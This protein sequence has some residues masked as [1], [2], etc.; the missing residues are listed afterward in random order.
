VRSV[1]P[2]RQ[3]ELNI[4][5]HADIINALGFATIQ[6]SSETIFNINVS[7]A[8][9]PTDVIASNIQISSNLLVGIVHP[10]VD[11]QFD[12]LAGIG[13]VTRFDSKGA[14]DTVAGPVHET[15]IHLKDS[16]MIFQIG[17]NPGQD[18]G[19]AIGRMDARAL[20]IKGISVTDRLKANEA[21]DA[22][23]RAM[24]MVSSARSKLGAIQNRLEHAVTSLGVAI[25]NLSSSES[26]IRDLDMAEEMVEFTKNQILLNA[27]TAMLAQANMKPQAIM[28]LL[29]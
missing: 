22:L 12:P 13:I 9:E 1:I 20:G 26:R 25:E 5:G 16:T 3:G 11:V 18:V 7:N 23:D 29:Q 17:P 28:Q 27:G 10:Y 6:H 8:H 4:F 24:D 2:G 21:M 15:Y 14:F 19:A